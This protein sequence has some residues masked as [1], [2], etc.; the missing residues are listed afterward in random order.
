MTEQ[1]DTE[2]NHLEDVIRESAETPKVME[3]DGQRVEER[4]VAEQIAADMYLCKKA[5]ARRKGC[6]IQ[7][8]KMKHSGS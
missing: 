2:Q 6:G 7:W 1:N 4:S 5:A 8:L 3:T